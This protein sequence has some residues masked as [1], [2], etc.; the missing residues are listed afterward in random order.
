MVLLPL[1]V[2]YMNHYSYTLIRLP[3]Q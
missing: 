3:K 1:F 2:V